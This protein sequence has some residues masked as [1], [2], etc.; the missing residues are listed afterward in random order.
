VELPEGFGYDPD[1]LGAG[2]GRSGYEE[3][4]EMSMV[5]RVAIVTGA[6]KGFG[7]AIAQRLARDG[8]AIVAADIHPTSAEQTAG[9][10]QDQ[11]G[12]AWACRVD[13][14]AATSV[15]GMVRFA[16]DRAGGR[17]DILVN[18]AGIWKSTPTEDTSEEDWDRVVDVNLK[19]V[20]LCCRAVIPIMKAQ[21]RGHIVNIASI[22]ARNGGTFS[23]IHYVASKAGIVGMTKKLAK[24]LGAAGIRV[25]GVNPGHSETGIMAGVDLTTIRESL[26]KN[27]PLGRAAE[28]ED[29]ADMVAFLVSDAARFVHGETIEVNGGLVC[30]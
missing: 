5:E 12:T 28:P 2:A 22:A 25:N 10:I 24:E 7:R 23:G 15:N 21:K 1:A 29:V 27:T 8:V 16:A 14:A 17:I 13:V 6:G 11:G 4:S 3:E 19:G 26:L 30:D 20:F 9:L 18:N